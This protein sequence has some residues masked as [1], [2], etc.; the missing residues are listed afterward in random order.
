MKKDKIDKNKM[1]KDSLS[2]SEIMKD[3]MGN[4][5]DRKEGIILNNC[6]DY[7]LNLKTLEKGQKRKDLKF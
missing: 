5:K 6:K 1:E 7:K 4:D 2:G 3:K